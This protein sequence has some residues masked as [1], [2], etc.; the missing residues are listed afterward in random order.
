MTVKRFIIDIC[1]IFLSMTLSETIK[2][3]VTDFS[4]FALC[5]SLLVLFLSLNFFFAKFKQL[6]E[7]DDN[8]SA[9]GFVIN[10]LTLMSF[11]AMP[12]F[13]TSLVGMMGTQIFLRVSDIL[14]ILYNNNWSFK[15]NQLER[16]WMIFDIVYL[17]VIIIFVILGIIFDNQALHI[18]LVA[19]YL[20]MGIFESD[21]DFYINKDSYGMIT[22]SNL[23]SATIEDPALDDIKAS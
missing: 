12:F 10:I 3:I 13:L 22:S 1:G 16:R 8:I 2:N 15:I 6:Q 18:I 7:G 9:F 11:A 14:L 17:F 23:E 4:L 20:F 5:S 19:T 21:F